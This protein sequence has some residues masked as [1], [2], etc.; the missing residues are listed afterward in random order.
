MWRGLGTNAQVIT[1]GGLGFQ[2]GP[3]GVGFSQGVGRSYLHDMAGPH[4]PKAL[5]M[6]EPH[7]DVAWPRHP[8]HVPPYFFEIGF[9]SLVPPYLT[10]YIRPLTHAPS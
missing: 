10:C 8:N 5:A 6:A 7:Y 4:W 1:S 2:R 3:F 9:R